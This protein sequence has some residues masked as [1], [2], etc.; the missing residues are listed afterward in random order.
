ML[1]L[2]ISLFSW[3]SLEDIKTI[4]LLLAMWN[5]FFSFPSALF[6]VQQ[7]CI[8]LRATTS[9]AIL[10]AAFLGHFL[11][12]WP[13]HV[14]DPCPRL[15]PRQ[16]EPWHFS[17][18]TLTPFFPSSSRSPPIPL[19]WLLLFHLCWILPLLLSPNFTLHSL[20]PIQSL[21]AT[22]SHL[23]L[24]PP[25]VFKHSSVFSCPRPIEPSCLSNYHPTSL[26]LFLSNLL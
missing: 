26:L 13:M 14:F 10:Y 2:L 18:R 20:E 23:S 1:V 15:C 8:T 24:S 5:P 22:F 16:W 19:S 4:I 7:F 9:L 12:D 25:A 6:V 3:M 17:F 11:W 21:V